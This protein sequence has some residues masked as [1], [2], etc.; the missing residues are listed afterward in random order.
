[1]DTSLLIGRENVLLRNWCCNCWKISIVDDSMV[2]QLEWRK[3]GD[4]ER[5]KDVRGVRRQVA[6]NDSV[7]ARAWKSAVYASFEAIQDQ[8]CLLIT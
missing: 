5:L 7:E 2:S 4:I 6:S 1:M 3:D 8:Q